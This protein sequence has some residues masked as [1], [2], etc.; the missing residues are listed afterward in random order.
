MNRTQW[1]LEQLQASGRVITRVYENKNDALAAYNRVHIV[2][3][4]RGTVLA[5]VF[6]RMTWAAYPD[7][8]IFSHDGPV[9]AHKSNWPTI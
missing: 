5:N 8:K 7:G 3:R 4:G 6:S 9:I 1:I 2:T